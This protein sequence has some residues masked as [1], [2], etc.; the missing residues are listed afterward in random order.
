MADLKDYSGGFNPNLR[1]FDFSKE[2]LIRLLI[3]A[4]K[5]YV[6]IDGVWTTLMREKFGDRATFDYDKEVR[7]W[8]SSG[9]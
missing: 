5:A 4:S 2:A 8:Q 7:F 1:L 9:A 3:S 6:G